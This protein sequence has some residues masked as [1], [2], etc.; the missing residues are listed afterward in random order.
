MKRTTLLICL[1]TMMTASFAQ[2][3]R[4][5]SLRGVLASQIV[6]TTRC[7]ALNTLAREYWS[8]RPDTSMTLLLQSA[9]IAEKLEDKKFLCTATNY[10]AYTFFAMGQYDSSIRVYKQVID[11]AKKYKQNK[12][13]GQSLSGLGNVYNTTSD[14]DEAIKC[15]MEALKVQEKLDDKQGLARTYNSLGVLFEWQNDYK[16]ALGY[17]ISALEL[18]RQFNDS[19][20]I[21]MT[22][23]NIG[24]VYYS[25]KDYRNSMKFHNEAL[26]I[27]ERIGD[28]KGLLM[29]YNN[30]GNIYSK[31]GR[32]DKAIELFEKANA[33]ANDVKDPQN[34]ANASISLGNEYF[35]MGKYDK[36]I[37]YVLKAEKLA[38]ELGI[39]ELQANVYGS[40]MKYY[41][42]KKEYKLALEYSQLQQEVNDSMFSESKVKEIHTL[43]TRYQ[44]EK[45]EQENKALQLENALSVKTIRQQ[46]TVTYFIII[47]LILVTGLAFFIFRGLKQQRKANTIISAQKEEVEHQKELVDEKNKEITDS[48]TYAKRIQTALLP[49]IETF[50]EI[51][52]NSFVLFKPKDI[53][54]GDFFWITQKDGF[55]FYV[56]ADCTGHGVPGAFMSM[57][58]TSFLNEIINEKDVTE[59]CD[60]LDL[61]KIKIIKSLKQKGE[62]GGSKDG[63][64]MVLC[65]L[66]PETN[67][68][69]FAAANNPLWLLRNGEMKEYKADKQPVGIGAEGFE[70]FN[71]HTIQLQKGDSVY[72]FSDGFADQFGGPKGK[73]FKYR[74]LEEVLAA[75]AGKTLDEQKTILDRHFEE[76]RGI[77]EQ[78]DD[79]CVIGVQI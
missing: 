64:D 45:K 73:K 40:L 7:K 56:A 66:N 76:W 20:A 33:L 60:I 50:S 25:M 78:V 54:S 29:S 15:Y 6:D 53:V 61:L 39:K 18:K 71:Q 77:L 44:T 62:V 27:R 22:L 21:A 3:K 8:T 72:I 42:M 49:S 55:I 4:I 13:L 19:V 34:V 2:N 41:T 59:P 24:V 14:Y 35:V 26:A 10:Q 57:L 16:K 30:M 43:N 58:G 52:P 65:R 5:D 11:M 79:V 70:H 31:Q 23:N 28:K 63:M 75:S 36:G 68:L 46:K 48:I 51:L 32:S 37:G 9:H 47:G 1:L 74:Q 67:E 38:N 12:A 69:V 17:H